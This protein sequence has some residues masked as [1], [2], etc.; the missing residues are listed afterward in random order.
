VKICF[1]A[2]FALGGLF[3]DKKE[4]RFISEHLCNSKEPSAA[5]QDSWWLRAYRHVMEIKHRIS[6]QQIVLSQGNHFRPRH[7]LVVERSYVH[8]L[9]GRLQTPGNQNVGLASLSRT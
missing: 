2:L 5:V 4:L 6:I 8:G 3:E 1:I 9:F 7:Y